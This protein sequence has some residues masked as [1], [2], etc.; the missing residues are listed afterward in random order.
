MASKRIGENLL[1]ECR[2]QFAEVAREL[3]VEL[4]LA[5]DF[6]ADQKISMDRIF[7]KKRAW[8][9]ITNL[10][11]SVLQIMSLFSSGPPGWVALAVTALGRLGFLFFEDREEKA[12]RQRKRLEKMLRKDVDEHESGMRDVLHRWFVQEVLRE[13]D[14]LIHDMSMVESHLSELANLQRGLA[15]TFNRKQKLLHQ[16]LLR[17][18][19]DQLGC[20]ETMWG[21][22]DVAR[23]PGHA[24]MLFKDPGTTFP[25][26]VERGLRRLLDERIWFVVDTGSK[27]SKLCQAIG[28]RKPDERGRVAIEE[29]SQVAHVPVDLQDAT[30]VA[31]TRLAQQLTEL[32]VMKE[33]G[34]A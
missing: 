9:W 4:R 26:D 21:V 19:L 17:E 15:W 7:D 11:T 12:N 29:H 5:D 23:I 8:K 14:S 34:G 25:D 1:S 10:G 28:I 31:R 22:R 2:A 32:H 24:V 6:A 13:V 3:Q 30:H 20:R 33:P 27:F 16:Q 18:A